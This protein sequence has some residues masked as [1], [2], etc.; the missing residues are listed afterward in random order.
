MSE[1]TGCTQS[2]DSASRKRCP[3]PEQ[4]EGSAIPSKSAKVSDA[5]EAA[6]VSSETCKN[7]EAESKETAG[8]QSKER[9]KE[10]AAAVQREQSSEFSSLPVNNSS[11][12]ASNS[13][14]PESSDAP[15]S[16][17]GKKNAA[18]TEAS[19]SSIPLE[20]TDSAAIAAAEAL[21][22]LTGGDGEDSRETPCSSE[23]VKP[24]KQGSKF[25]QRGA[26]QSSR[27]GSRTQA[28]AA[29]SSTSVHSTDREDAD[30]MQ[31]A[32]EGDESISGSS[33]TPSSSFPSDNE[34]NDDGECAIVS[35]KMA[36]EMRQSVALLAQVQMRLEALEKKGA[37]LHQK[38]ELKISRQ[39][40]PQLD[41]RSSIMKTI[42]GFW[43]TALLNHPH[44]SAHIDETDEDALSYMTDLE[45]ESFKN[46]KLGYRIR[47]HFRRNPYFQNNIIMKELHLGMG[48]SPMS[49]SNPI[50]WHR[51]HNLTAHS[52]PRKSSHGVYQTFF[53]WFGDHSNPG[54]DDVAQILKDD[55][56]RDPLRYYLTPLWE[57]RENGSGGSGARAADNGNGD[58]CVVISDSDEEPG[59]DAGEADQGHSREEE[60]E[61]E[62]EDEE[63][64]AEE[65]EEEEKGPSADESPEEGEEDDAGEL[66]IDGS[67]DSEQD[68]EEEA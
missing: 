28:A 20:Q 4:D 54:Q 13:E 38:L 62:E 14:K 12:G 3:S 56:F 46:N 36:P 45:I 22:S 60:E 11:T 66:V 63:E 15:G 32:E 18:K 31:E 1:L 10:S 23:K 34:D 9:E 47:F 26:H 8:S 59:E 49:F 39:R 37:R 6:R 64:A 16:A 33:S 2:A 55:L 30:D 48:G 5:P 24:A 19:K 61:E 44:L 52:E 67:D 27:V 29:D 51:G 40:R 65:E 21:A 43:V 17:G 57:P 35:V 25:K 41:Q 53:S 42:P 50:L 58:D 7:S 68:E